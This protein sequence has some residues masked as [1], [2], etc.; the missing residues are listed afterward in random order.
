MILLGQLGVRSI[1]CSKIRRLD[2]WVLRPLGVWSIRCWVTLGE[3]SLGVQSLGVQSLGVRYVY[4]LD[5]VAIA[6]LC[7]SVI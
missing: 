6:E 4:R 1:K 3:V 7:W 2:H 5:T